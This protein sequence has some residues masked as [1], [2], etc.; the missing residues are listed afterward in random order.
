MTKCILFLFTL[1]TICSCRITHKLNY[2][3]PYRLRYDTYHFY[4]GD[5]CTISGSESVINAKYYFRGDTLIVYSPFQKVMTDV[6]Y[7]FESSDGDILD[8]MIYNNG[9]LVSKNGDYVFNIP[10]YSFEL[11]DSNR[12]AFP[13]YGQGIYSS[14]KYTYPVKYIRISAISP[15]RN[16]IYSDWIPLDIHEAGKLNVFIHSVGPANRYPYELHK[17]IFI[18][19]NKLVKVDSNYKKL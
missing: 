15:E 17:K 18:V 19:R 11:F 1:I 16:T 10:V 6:Q 7:S 4:K 13:Q 5:S 3:K 9:K 8:V 14:N 12:N 2:E